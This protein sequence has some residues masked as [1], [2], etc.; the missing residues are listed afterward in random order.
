MATKLKPVDFAK[1]TR[2]ASKGLSARDESRADASE[3]PPLTDSIPLRQIKPRAH[4]N[5]RALN[6]THLLHLA[7]SIEEMGLIEPIV[8]DAK[9]H[10]LAGGHRLVACQLLNPKLRDPVIADLREKVTPKRAEEF[11]RL[12]SSLPERSTLDARRIPV[13]IFNFDSTQDPDRAI[14]VETTENTQRRDYTPGEVYEL[15]QALIN[16][17]YTEVTG[18]P[19]AGQ[20]PVKPALAT[21][22][23]RSLRTVKRKLDQAQRPPAD[24]LDL[25]RQLDQ[26]YRLSVKLN[27]QLEA[28]SEETLT[29]LK[30]RRGYKSIARELRR[31]LK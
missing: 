5:T 22:I 19:K 29:L 21:L 6:P 27:R 14:E 1:R 20:L 31:A 8:I 26:I 11:D 12:V 3:R 13:R 17:G 9:N 4:G 7:L 10:L 28:C 15:Y 18:R 24:E 30:S 2:S 23:G 25:E 16:K